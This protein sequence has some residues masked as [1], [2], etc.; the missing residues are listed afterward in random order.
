L[1]ENKKSDR[2]ELG[3]Y[4]NQLRI[5]KKLYK[6]EWREQIDKSR[7]QMKLQLKI[8]TVRKKES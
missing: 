3:H 2:K 5:K 7:L 8:K 1:I 4:N 6:E